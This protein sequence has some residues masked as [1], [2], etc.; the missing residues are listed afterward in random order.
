MPAGALSPPPPQS[1]GE[2]VVPEERLALIR[3]HVAML[4]ETARAVGDDLPLTAD[5]A[6][7]IR[8]LEAEEG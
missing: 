3:A 1:L 6:D 2:H 5:A 4:S 7:F 8:V